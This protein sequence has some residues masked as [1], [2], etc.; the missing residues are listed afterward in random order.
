MSKIKALKIVNS[1]LAIVFLILVLTALFFQSIP[2]SIYR[3]IHPYT[4]YV[5]TGLVILHIILNFGWIKNN[6]LKKK[7]KH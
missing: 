3:V 7:N 6:V 5:F 2:Y 4:G 1:A